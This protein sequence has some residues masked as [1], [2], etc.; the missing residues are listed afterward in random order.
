[1]INVIKPITLKS[2]IK[3]WR[4]G[5]LSRRSLLG[6]IHKVISSAEHISLSTMF[7]GGGGSQEKCARG[8]QVIK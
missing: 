1:M 7:S 6:K 3:N 8:S 4:I 2:Y 5:I